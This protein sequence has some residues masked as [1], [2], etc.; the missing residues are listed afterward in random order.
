MSESMKNLPLII[1]KLGGSIITD[2]Q[3]FLMPKKSVITNILMVIA[4][5]QNKYKFLIVHGAGSFGH[6]YAK[7]FHIKQGYTYPEQLFGIQQTHEAMLALNNTLLA[8]GKDFGLKFLTFPPLSGCITDNG[9]IQ[10][11]NVD[12]FR[13]ALEKNF[14]PV[15]FGDVVFDTSLSFTILSGD[16]VVPFLALALHAGKILMLTD[17]NGI[18]DKHPKKE[19]AAKLLQTVNIGDTALLNTIFSG[20][21]DKIRVTG[22]MENKLLELKE[23]VLRNIETWVISGLDPTIL[24]MHL[25]NKTSLLG[26]RLVYNKKI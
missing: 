17:V 3:T 22:E 23:V 4:E 12:I 16:Q 19:P 7:T 6:P 20:S 2:D 5:F 14:I 15:T 26:T 9:R 24:R 18:Y 11:W 10:S 8:I 25:E 1:I 13:L 21:T